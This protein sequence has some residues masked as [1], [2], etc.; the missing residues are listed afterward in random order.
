MKLLL[1]FQSALYIELMI[2]DSEVSLSRRN[3]A[4][5]TNIIVMAK[6]DRPD[7]NVNSHVENKVGCLLSF[8]YQPQQI[9][10]AVK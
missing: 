4:A 10:T 2:G 8:L 9:K 1:E 5:A 7:R 3:I 6:L